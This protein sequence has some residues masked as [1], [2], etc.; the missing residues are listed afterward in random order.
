[1]LVPN[2]HFLQQK[3]TNWTLSDLKIR[4]S[5]SVGVAYGSPTRETERVIM[6]AIETHPMVLREPPPTILFE[7]FGDSALVFT[8]YFWMELISNRDNRVAVSEIRH[9]IN[10]LIEKAGI[11]ISFPQRDVHVDSSKPLEVN[12]L[13]S[14]Q[15]RKEQ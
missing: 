8:G 3:V 14:G 4:Y 13:F 11:V 1:M 7:E 5:V 10:E 6:K 9:A 15:E 12:V 2:S